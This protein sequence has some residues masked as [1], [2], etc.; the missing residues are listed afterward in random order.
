MSSSLHT[1]YMFR[2]T[3]NLWYNHQYI[4]FS[5]ALHFIS[6]PCIALYWGFLITHRHT[7]ELLW[8][9]D[10]PV[11][12]AS[13]YT[14]NTRDKHS[15]PQ[16]NSNPQT[17]KPSVRRPT[18]YTELRPGSQYIPQLNQ[19]WVREDL[20][21]A[22]SHPGEGTGN[23][24]FSIMTETAL[25]QSLGY[26]QISAG[27]KAA[28]MWKGFLPANGITVLNTWSLTSRVFNVC[29]PRCLGI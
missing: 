15:C 7:V 1:C 18:S 23:F 26:W 21:L 11:A 19:N 20:C 12:E 22:G 25:G 28:G 17:Q 2:P 10:Q 3:Q 14:E 29:R 8:T 5:K 24:L 4:C 9:S 16:R 13:I 27:D 6:E